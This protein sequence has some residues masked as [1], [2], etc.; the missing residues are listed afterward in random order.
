MKGLLKVMFLIGFV[1]VTAAIRL[2]D[3][4][5]WRNNFDQNSAQKFDEFLL[6]HNNRENF[7]AIFDEHSGSSNGEKIYNDYVNS[8]RHLKNSL[9][10]MNLS[11]DSLNSQEW[12]YDSKQ[13][14]FILP[15]GS[16]VILT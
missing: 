9:F 2:E 13:D 10:K 4:G 3:R 12:K 7:I 1:N 14:R 11:R 16:K 15:D 5:S 8:E 6:Q